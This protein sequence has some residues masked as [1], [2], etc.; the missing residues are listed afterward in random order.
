MR[1]RQLTRLLDRAKLSP[2]KAARELGV[3]GMTLRR[4]RG[5]ASDAKLPELYRRAAEPLVRRLVAEG[6]VHPEDPDA[7][8]VFAR[9]GGDPF[10]KTLLAVGITPEVLAEPDAKSG[11]VVMGLARIGADENRQ[12][13]VKASERMFER[14]RKMSAE[15]KRRLDDLALVLRSES[16]PTLDKLV[17]FGALFYLIAPFDL[18]PDAIPLFG[19]VDDFIIL[20]IAALYFRTRFPKLF[21]SRAAPETPKK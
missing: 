7:A 8:A 21:A 3:S 14:F 5:K 11:T 13:Q 9:S 19:Y 6:L 16:V 18:I 12:T 17:A 2:E 10:Q 20:G 1:Y 15:W 4:W